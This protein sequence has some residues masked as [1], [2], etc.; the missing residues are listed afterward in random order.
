M[1]ADHA[2]I[3]IAAALLTGPD[4]SKA[5]LADTTTML[6]LRTATDRIVRGLLEPLKIVAPLADATRA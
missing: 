6:R 5:D 3:L 4:F 1:D 2:R